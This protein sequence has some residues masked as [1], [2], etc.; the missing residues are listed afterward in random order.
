MSDDNNLLFLIILINFNFGQ[1]SFK[2]C[3]KLSSILQYT[4]V[5]STKL[6][7]LIELTKPNLHPYK[8][9]CNFN[10]LLCSRLILLF[11]YLF[12]FIYLKSY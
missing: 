8:S 4:K 5:N 11:L 6:V 12:L 1:F 9:I 7:D 3:T 10:I 2:F